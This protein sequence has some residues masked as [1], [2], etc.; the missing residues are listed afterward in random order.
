[1]PFNA[2]NLTFKF[3]LTLFGM[4]GDTFIP[5]S[6]LDH[7]LS[8]DFFS[9]ISKLFW[10][11]KLTSIG[12]FWHSAQLIESSYK[13]GSKDEHF[14]C[15]HMS[16]QT[17]LNIHRRLENVHTKMMSNFLGSF[18]ILIHVILFLPYHVDF[19]EGHFRPSEIEH[20]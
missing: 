13:G 8:A 17:G 7:I 19:V 14:S 16:C 4:G 9:K 1:M 10:R 15:F 5:L 2:N 11:W 20:R 18:L 12:L 6:F 3:L